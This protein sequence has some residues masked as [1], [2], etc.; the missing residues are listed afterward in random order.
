MCERKRTL[1]VNHLKA[2]GFPSSND[3]AIIPVLKDLGFLTADGTPTAR[4]HEYRNSARSRKVLG[5]ALREAYGELFHIN[6][7]PTKNDR[8]A[9]EGL[10]KSTHNTTDRLAELQA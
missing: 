5:E 6:A 10:F 2:I 1:S 4:Y 3:R 9:I 8:D 7:R